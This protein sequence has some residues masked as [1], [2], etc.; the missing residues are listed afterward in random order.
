MENMTSLLFVVLVLKAAMLRDGIR[1]LRVGL[2]SQIREQKEMVMSES[3]SDNHLK[4]RESKVGS[5]KM[6]LPFTNCIPEL[7]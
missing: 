6:P 3:I 2:L 1:L 5:F 4:K 7:I